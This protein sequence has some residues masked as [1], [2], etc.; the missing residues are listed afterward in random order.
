MNE[1]KQNRVLSPPF[2]TEVSIQEEL[3]LPASFSRLTLTNTDPTV[4]EE[5]H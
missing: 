4:L 1:R 3:L 5:L 2:Y